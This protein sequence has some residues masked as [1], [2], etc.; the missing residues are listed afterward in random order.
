MKL[1]H[2]RRGDDESPQFESGV[3]GVRLRGWVLVLVAVALAAVTSFGYLGGFLAPDADVSGLPILIVN[4]DRGAQLGSSSLQFGDQV[5]DQLGAPS[6]ALGDT[7]SWQVA[8]NREEALIRVRQDRAYAALIIPADFSTRLAAIATAGASEP[9]TIEVLTNPASGSYS[10]AY[11]QAIATAAVDQVSRQSTRQLATTLEGLGVK[12]SP[13]AAVTVGRPVEATVTVAHPIGQRGG[14]GLAPFY[15]AVV[16]VVAALFATS[17]LN[18]AVDVAAGHQRLSVLGRKVRFGTLAGK[19]DARGSLRA[20][21]ALAGP[22]AA[23]VG[24]T[25]TAVALWPL[26]MNVVRPWPL[27]SFAVLGAAAMAA[28]TLAFYTAFD[29]AGSVLA[30]LFLVIYGVPSSGGVY[31]VEALPGFFRFLHA[32]LPLRYLTD[33]V[34]SLTFGGGPPGAVGRAVAVLA[35]YALTGTGA[36]IAAASYTARRQAVGAPQISEFAVG[37]RDASAG[38]LPDASASAQTKG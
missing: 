21:L 8:T 25:V 3:V 14:R 9:A 35:V 28:V 31:P 34:R 30:A 11:S 4:L 19:R 10:G 18:V 17:A 22:V 26:D 29:L 7:V 37:S 5:I 15:F 36:A 16:V 13:A 23:A 33:G 32:W 20:K 12:L 1:P 2:A 24:V 38:L 6:P 27:A